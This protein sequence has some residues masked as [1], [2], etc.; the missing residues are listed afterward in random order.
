ML[1]MYIVRFSITCSIINTFIIADILEDTGKSVSNFPDL[2]KSNRFVDKTM[3]I[4]WFAEQNQSLYITAPKRFGKSTN[5]DMLQRFFEIPIDKDGNLIDTENSDNYK[6]F[7]QVYFFNRSHLAIFKESAFFKANFGKWPVLKLNFTY[8]ETSTF[9]RFLRSVALTL[10]RAFG[11][12]HFLQTSKFLTNETRSFM[13]QLL[14]NHTTPR[15]EQEAVQ[16]VLRSKCA[17]ETHFN[18]T[19]LVLIDGLDSPLQAM[20]A[21]HGFGRDQRAIMYCLQNLIKGIFQD[22]NR[23]L[24]LGS[25][26]LAGVFDFKKINM[27]QISFHSNPKAA[28]FFGSTEQEAEFLLQQCSPSVNIK[29]AESLFGGHVVSG[30]TEETNATSVNLFCTYAVRSYCRTGQVAPHSGELSF[31][32]L[33]SLFKITD[34]T[35]AILDLLLGYSY[36]VPYR[37]APELVD[38]IKLEAFIDKAKMSK[39]ELPTVPRLIVAF[40]MQL[41]LE[42]GYF[43]VRNTTASAVT[44]TIPNLEVKQG[45]ANCMHSWVSRFYNIEINTTEAYIKS[46]KAL[47]RSTESQQNFVN[48]VAALFSKTAKE[49]C[50]QRSLVTPI[51]LFLISPKSE[52]V[53][54]P[55]IHK[56]STLFISRTMLGRKTGIVITVAYD[57]GAK[58]SSREI[59][60]DEITSFLDNLR[61]G[62]KGEVDFVIG[63][64]DFTPYVLWSALTYNNTDEDAVNEYSC[65]I[66]KSKIEGYDKRPWKL[67]KQA[68]KW[69]RML[70]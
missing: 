26:P 55:T 12:S 37:K 40:M 31:P 54:I 19:C 53:V 65:I 64:L 8:I 27:R 18:K 42:F 3:F 41:L 14:S 69:T 25:L 48:S 33:D 63:R 68:W 35:S 2:A 66:R 1:N 57:R 32:L 29:I 44:L 49:P 24:C 16:F 22:N 36:Y 13:E 15:N 56:S 39:G 7:S 4:K 30:E 67:L 28:S 60:M 62:F 5:L 52:F 10:R 43:S 6:L 34:L 58:I 11:S 9:N 50:H 59:M 21:I 38:Y 70:G 51:L 61:V 23:A 20:L 17:L 46:A 45:L 47:G